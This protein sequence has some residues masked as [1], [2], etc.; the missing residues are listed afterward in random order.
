MAKVQEP[1]L[2]TT[3]LYDKA[4]EDWGVCSKTVKRYLAAQET[5]L[6]KAAQ[7]EEEEEGGHC[8]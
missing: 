2:T 4:M 1:G 7:G 8:P 6:V 3:L 5:K